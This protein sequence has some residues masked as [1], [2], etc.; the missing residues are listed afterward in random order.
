MFGLNVDAGRKWLVL[1]LLAAISCTSV[2][3]AERSPLPLE[4]TSIDLGQ[5]SPAGREE[6]AGDFARK[7]GGYVE[8]VYGVPAADWVARMRATFTA[9]DPVNFRR[10]L[11]RDTFE[12]ALA[13]LGGVGYRLND[14]QVIDTLA[15]VKAT[16]N[17]SSR[18]AKIS[19]SVHSA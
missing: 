2:V 12:G 11:D 3:H 19:L 10:S 13:E 5:L 17:K 18:S 4:N 1:G 8:R 9:A 14:D 7:W 15:T 6:M 16:L